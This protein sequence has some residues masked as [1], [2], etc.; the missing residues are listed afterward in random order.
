MKQCTKV[1]ILADSRSNKEQKEWEKLL[2]VLD[3]TT[4]SLFDNIL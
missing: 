4:I 2:Y 1:Q 3:S